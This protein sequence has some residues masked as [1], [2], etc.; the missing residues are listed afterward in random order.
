MCPL[1]WSR[2]RRGVWVA[3]VDGTRYA[4]VQSRRDKRW[5]ARR[6]AG[7]ILTTLPGRFPTLA[8]AQQQCRW[9]HTHPEDACPKR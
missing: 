2:L 3:T 9:T 8:A 5:L 4:A 1:D 6:L 7:G